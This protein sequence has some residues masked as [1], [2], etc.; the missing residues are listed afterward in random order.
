MKD[1]VIVANDSKFSYK[2]LPFGK[3]FSFGGNSTT[4]QLQDANTENLDDGYVN[5]VTGTDNEYGGYYY[6]NLGAESSSSVLYHGFLKFNISSIPSNQ[7][8]ESAEMCLLTSNNYIDTGESMTIG[9]YHVYSFPSF[10]ITNE[11]VSEW[12][13]GDSDDYGDIAADKEIS[14]NRR[15]TTASEY[16]STAE[17]EIV[18]TSSTS[19]W[20][21]WTVVN[22]VD[23]EYANED[24]NVSIWLQGTDYSANPSTTDFCRFHAKET[25]TATNRPYLNIT[26]SEAVGGDTCDWSSGDFVWD[27]SET[28][29]VDTDYDIAGNDIIATGTGNITVAA[30]ITNC[31]DIR[32]NPDCTVFLSPDNKIE[33]K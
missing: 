20:H 23:N 18:L 1:S 11:T 29:T 22:A 30:N 31:D 10:N 17:E 14:W 21:C 19:G 28:C 12:E 7:V 33:C 3:N 9:S 16:N 8:I 4:I 24:L 26:Y 2:G 6:I 13:E 25:G 5:A 27:C 32:I 15:P